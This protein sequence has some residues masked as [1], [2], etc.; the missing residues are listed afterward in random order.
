MGTFYRLVYGT[1]L[2]ERDFESNYLEKPRRFSSWTGE[3]LC[4]AMGTSV[5]KT[6][7]DIEYTRKSVGP[8]RDRRIAVGPIDGSGVVAATPAI[9]KPSHHTWWRP[10][11]DEAW[12]EFRV[13]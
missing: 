5:C 11:G 8:L 1:E 9:D 4:K 10:K 13:M 6:L 12:K 2:S 7:E 3:R